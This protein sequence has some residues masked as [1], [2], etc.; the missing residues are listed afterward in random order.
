VPLHVKRM[1]PPVQPGK[2][3]KAAA[4]KRSRAKG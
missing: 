4:K 3:K 1:G 2:K